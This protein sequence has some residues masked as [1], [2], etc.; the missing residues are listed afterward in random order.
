MSPELIYFG[1]PLILTFLVTIVV[2]IV[3]TIRSSYRKS[4]GKP[5]PDRTLSPGILFFIACGC[6]LIVLVTYYTD[7]FGIG[8]LFMIPGFI[9]TGLAAVRF[10]TQRQ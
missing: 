3:L 1:S 7:Y 5:L 4:I 6:F 8:A 10:F 2:S 9:S